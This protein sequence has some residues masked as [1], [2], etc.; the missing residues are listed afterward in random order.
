[1]SLSLSAQRELRD[2]IN[3]LEVLSVKPV[4]TSE[5]RRKIDVLK[6]KISAVKSGSISDELRNADVDS[7]LREVGLPVPDRR[8]DAKAEV[9]ERATLRTIIGAQ[10]EGRSKEFRTYS[11]LV[12]SGDPMVPQ[13][14]I[15]KLQEAQ[16]SAGPLFAGSP[17]LTDVSGG[18]T[19]PTKI[20]VMDDTSTGTGYD[21][22][23]D[24][25]ET[26]QNPSLS[27]VSST[28]SRFSSGIILYSLELSDDVV[29]FDKLTN[30]LARSLGR[31]VSRIQNQTFLASVMTALAANSSAGALS[32][33]TSGLVSFDDVVSLVGSVN[34]AYRTNASFLMNSKTATQIGK[35]KDSQGRPI[36]RD[37]LAPQPKLL[38]YDVYI[39]DFCDDPNTT[40]NKP[41]IFGD[42]STLYSRATDFTIQVFRE[43]FIDQGSYAVV[44]RRRADVQYT[45]PTTADSALKYLTIS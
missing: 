43:R 40:E 33:E 15:T 44:A 3:E 1:M 9:E 20:P 26:Y 8:A 22:T 28:L 35:L 2:L 36:L 34:G 7:L 24:S 30:V 14:F 10:F 31:R 21:V 37:I 29:A 23:E 19:G 12:S 18:L 25:Q 13:G 5:E 6:V 41:V 42:F 17:L 4:V 11:G 32:S 27:N 16:I 45:I 39:G 38:G